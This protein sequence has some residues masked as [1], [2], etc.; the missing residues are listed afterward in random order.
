VVPYTVTPT[1]APYAYTGWDATQVSWVLSGTF[2]FERDRR[3]TSAATWAFFTPVK[4][5]GN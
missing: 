2:T 5:G 3:L 1:L 4:G